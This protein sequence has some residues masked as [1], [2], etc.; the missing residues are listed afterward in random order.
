MEPDIQHFKGALRVL[1]KDPC[2]K[3]SSTNSFDA[4]ATSPIARDRGFGGEMGRIRFSLS[5]RFLASLADRFTIPT[6]II[7]LKA[8]ASITLLHPIWDASSDIYMM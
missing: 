6:T 7:I 4:R 1:I 3:R 8:T 5:F 2:D